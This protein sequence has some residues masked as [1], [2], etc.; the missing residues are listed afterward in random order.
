MTSPLIH[1]F[2]LTYYVKKLQKKEH[3]AFVGYSDAEWFCILKHQLGNLTGLGQVLDPVIGELLGQVLQDRKNDP[4]F[5]FAVPSCMWELENFTEISIDRKDKSICDRIEQYLSDHNLTD[6]VFHERDMVLDDC[7]RD[8]GLYPF[9]E[10]LQKMHTVIIGPK[11]L[12]DLDF[13]DYN[14]FI[15]I[16]NPNLHMEKDGIKTAVQEALEYGEKAVYLISAGLSAA[17]IIHN[18]WDTIPESIFMDCGSI[19][20]GFVGIGGQRPWREKLYTNPDKYKMWR[21]KNLYGYY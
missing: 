1:K 11:P 10:Q 6:I 15:E 19:W 7:A 2:P 3:F 9:I 14:H 17:L 21:H 20:D 12:H 5:L 16:S 13:L 8:A 18:L 4:N